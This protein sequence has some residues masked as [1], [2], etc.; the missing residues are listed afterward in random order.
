M[1]YR[2]SPCRLKKWRTRKT[3]KKSVHQIQVRYLN[4]SGLLWLRIREAF[5]QVLGVGEGELGSELSLL[6]KNRSGSGDV[7]SAGTFQFLWK[8]IDFVS[9]RV[10]V[11]GFLLGYGLA[12]GCLWRRDG[13]EDLSCLN[14]ADKKD[15]KKIFK[16]DTGTVPEPIQVPIHQAS[17]D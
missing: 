10:K 2:I 6:P 5:C 9:C 12:Y 13:I 15:G 4:L 17:S 16:P 11:A 1:G 8:S 14:M 3:V 7:D